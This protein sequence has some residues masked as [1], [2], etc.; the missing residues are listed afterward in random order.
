VDRRELAMKTGR[1]LLDAIAAVFSFA[2]ELGLIE[3]NPVD[4]FRRTL[5]RKSRTKRGRAENDPGRDIRP[6]EHPAEIAKLLEAARGE[7]LETHVLVMLLRDAG[8]RVGEA[9]GLRWRAV[10]W[11]DDDQDR[12][13]AL[14][15][16]TSRQRGGEAEAPK[17]GRARKVQLSRRL[18]GA[19]F[20]LH[21]QRERPAPDTFVLRRPVGTF[22]NVVW[23]RIL[24]AADIGHRRPKDLRDTFAS[25]LLSAGVQLGYVSTQLGHADF[26]VTVRHY[27]KWAGGDEYRTAL[28]LEPGEVPADLLARLVESPQAPLIARDDVTALSELDR[29]TAR[30]LDAFDHA[31]SYA[32][33]AGL[34]AGTGFE[35]VTFGL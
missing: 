7:G 12:R 5:S 29:A 30:D 32:D 16:D 20:A 6:I 14:L 2:L 21:R 24:Q 19:L 13:R 33:G 28:T 15:I 18:R 22:R 26:G 31:A 27:A 11:G 35:P 23:P 4:G 25:Q 1:N 34:V 3:S 8:L 17:S 9:L 10:T